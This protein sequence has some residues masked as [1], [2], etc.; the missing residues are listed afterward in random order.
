MRLVEAVVA[1]VRRQSREERANSVQCHHNISDRA[2][3]RCVACVAQAERQQ[4][5]NFVVTLPRCLLHAFTPSLTHRTATWSF[6]CSIDLE[7]RLRFVHYT[8]VCCKDAHSCMY[9]SYV[10][11]TCMRSK[12]VHTNGRM[13]SDISR[14]AF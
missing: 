4:T 3:Q 9:T 8:A 13:V 5:I 10:G 12:Y 2:R 6:T 14:R 11:A 1:V 7:S